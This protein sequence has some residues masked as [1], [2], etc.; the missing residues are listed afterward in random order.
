MELKGRLKAVA[1]FIKDVHTMADIGT[2]HAYLPVYLIQQG[3]VAKAIACDV[4]MGPCQAARRTIA[5][6]G[7]SEKIAV[8]LGDGLRP[9]NTNEVEAVA[10][11]GMG[12]TTMIDILTGAPQVITSLGSLILQPMNSALQLRKWLVNNKWLIVDEELVLEDGRLYEIIYA[13]PGEMTVSE[14]IFYE[15][16]PCLW[17]KQH[18]LLPLHLENLLKQATKIMQAMA[19]NSTAKQS[20]KYQQLQEKANV[21]KGMLECL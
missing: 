7:L 15:V 2:D 13:K 21:L 17:E 10:I 6:A 18:N 1:S 14:E 11:A 16:G 4:N 20:V 5:A 3:I 8:R 19:E 12:G 9:L